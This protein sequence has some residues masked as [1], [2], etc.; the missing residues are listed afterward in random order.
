MLV[1]VPVG[2]GGGV[3]DKGIDVLVG[4]EVGVGGVVGVMLGSG[5]GVLVQVGGG[6]VS[7]GKITGVSVEINGVLV[8]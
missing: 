6:V 7:V 3:G 4:C 1:G 2:K 8:G 5:G